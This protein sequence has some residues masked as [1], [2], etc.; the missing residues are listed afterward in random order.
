[1]K[2]LSKSRVQ[3]SVEE[4][5]NIIDNVQGSPFVN[6][7]MK[8]LHR[9]VLKKS[10][11]DGS[12]NPFYK[13]IFKVTEK[14]YKIVTNYEKRVHNNLVK[15]EKDPNDFEVQSP[16]GKKHL[17]NCILTDTK[18]E[19]KRYIMVEWFPEVKG[20]TEYFHIDTPIEKVVFEK[21]IS[22]RENTNTKQGLDR[23]VT[24]IT[25]DFDNILE[26]T[27]MGVRYVLQH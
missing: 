23:N 6:I 16:S 15:E 24:P 26:M 3:V 9:E 22:E 17:T 10:K 12:E 5:V 27:F 21:W 13:E 1:M 14:T 4:L 8:T 20:K 2:V 19:T 18:T 7:K 11:L 25:P